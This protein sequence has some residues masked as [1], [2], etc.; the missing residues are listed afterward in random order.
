MSWF[1]L[2]FTKVLPFVADVF[3]TRDVRQ[4]GDKLFGGLAKR[5]K[6]VAEDPHEVRRIAEALEE[7]KGELTG[8]LVA[9]TP[10]A[11]LVD[12]EFMPPGSID[13][14]QEQVEI[15]A[16]TGPTGTTGTSYPPGENPTT[17]KPGADVAEDE[18]DYDDSDDDDEDEKDDDQDEKPKTKTKTTAKK[19]KK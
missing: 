10:A 14:T 13:P 3:E 12:E 11:G 16:A 19:K 7:K 15:P 9:R 2:A 8:A 17:N 4:S 6:E 18:F 1:T 5:L